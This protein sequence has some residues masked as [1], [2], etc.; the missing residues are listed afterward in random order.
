MQ[1]N[2]FK[3]SL[4][5]LIIFHISIDNYSQR[6]QSRLTATYRLSKLQKILI[7]QQDFRPFPT[8]QERES[9]MVL[10]EEVRQVLI[11]RAEEYLNYQWP[12]LTATLFLDFVRTGDRESFQ[13]PR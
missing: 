10:A 11:S 1:N 5:L 9:W 8:W 3:L 13:K 12:S 6:K 2:I 4:I 7:P